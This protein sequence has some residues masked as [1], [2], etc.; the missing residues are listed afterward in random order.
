M[1]YNSS[2]SKCFH[3]E[4]VVAKKKQTSTKFLMKE[5]FKFCINVKTNK[6]NTLK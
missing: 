1:I 6:G 5:I 4:H 2:N 3:K